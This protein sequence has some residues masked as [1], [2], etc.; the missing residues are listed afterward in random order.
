MVNTMQL[1]VRSRGPE[2][3][4]RADT[5]AAVNQSSVTQKAKWVLGRLVKEAEGVRMVLGAGEIAQW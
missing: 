5:G 1:S 2:I 3:P 4:Y